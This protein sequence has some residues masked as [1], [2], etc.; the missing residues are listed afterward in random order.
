[1]IDPM[2]DQF[3][4]LRAVTDA[5]EIRSA[6]TAAT[7]VAMVDLKLRTLLTDVASGNEFDTTATINV[8]ERL[9]L[10]TATSFVQPLV[11]VLK[12]DPS[13]P[14]RNLTSFQLQAL[15]V[16][17]VRSQM[18]VLD[19]FEADLIQGRRRAEEARTGIAK[20]LLTQY[21]AKVNAAKLREGRAAT[22]TRDDYAREVVELRDKVTLY[23]T[24][25]ERAAK[26]VDMD[27]DE[28]VA[29]LIRL[30]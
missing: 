24:A 15:Y 26:E 8:L 11:N 3:P 14:L 9:G 20:I 25:L 16:D 10:S 12:R 27:V 4:P 2:A 1:M 28:F 7:T 23:E 13:S 22:R 5:T 6:D 30:Q 29:N 21:K 18:I 17:N 19:E